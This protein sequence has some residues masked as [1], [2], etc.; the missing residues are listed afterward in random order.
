MI[1]VKVVVRQK[2][3]CIGYAVDLC[4]IEKIRILQI[5]VKIQVVNLQDQEFI[6]SVRLTYVEKKIHSRLAFVENAIIRDC[7]DIW[8]IHPVRI[9]PVVHKYFS[10]ITTKRQK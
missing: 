8:L 9:Y 3:K 2:Q 1:S 10:V 6:G 4:A 7:T 5:L